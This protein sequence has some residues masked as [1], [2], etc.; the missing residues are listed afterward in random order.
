MALLSPTQTE[1]LRQEKEWRKCAK[2]AAY[3]VNE[4]AFM[5][6]KEGGDPLDWELWDC[7]R[8]ALDQ[9][10]KHRLVI[11]LKT[12]QLGMSWTACAYVVWCVV[13]KLNFHV[14]FQ[15][16]GRVEVAE[17]MHRIHFIYDNLPEWMQRRVEM[18][19]RNLKDNDSLIE[20][21]NG[22]AIHSVATTK[23]AGHGS[24]PSLYILDEFA[25][26][27]QDVMAW[28]AVKP[29]LAAKGQVIVVSTANGIGNRFHSLWV[30]AETKANNLHPI[31]YPAS[32]HPDYTPEFLAK[33][34]EDYAGDL[35]GYYEAYPSTPE[36]AFMSSARCP[37]DTARINEHLQNI[38]ANGIKPKVGRLR[39]GNNGVEFLEDKTGSYL[40]WK[41]P[42]KG[43]EYTDEHGN[44]RQRP[45]HY[46]GIGTDI[47][48][49]LVKGD[50][51]VA[52]VIDDDTGEVVA[53]FRQKIAPEHL[54]YQLKMLG[55]YYGNAFLAV[56]VNV[57]SDLIMDDLKASY[58]W[59]YTRLKQERIYDVPTLEVGFRTT[60][61]SKP[62]I[63][64]QMRRYFDSR[65]KPLKIYSP[66]ILN[67]MAAFEEDDRGRLRASGDAHD[68]CVMATAIAIECCATMPKFNYD[69]EPKHR[70]LGSRSL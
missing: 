6:T 51:T 27:E 53:M 2:N 56:E 50:W 35:V 29:A 63:I 59:L 30:G 14:Y 33:E 40:I 66:T 36:E 64:T 54:A 18:G 5:W 10:Q 58:A 41:E 4:Y 37:F 42:L 67:E 16:I 7:Q 61:S 12:R 60:S 20:L 68:D 25:R 48:E 8:D 11:I 38:S 43:Q 49:G 44:K 55:E 24:A 21:S 69:Y 62:R 19:G 47:A 23:R 15:S 70:T 45:K 1:A 34:L 3:F 46:Y 31:F 26:N 13:F 28:R 57:N 39:Y 65:E 17:Q 32:S 22:S 9:F 52:V